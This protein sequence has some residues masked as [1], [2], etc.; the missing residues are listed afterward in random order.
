MP[1]MKPPMPAAVF[2]SL[3][4]HTGAG[5]RVA[6]DFERT[7]GP[8]KRRGEAAGQH[9]QL[10]ARKAFPVWAKPEPYPQ[11]HRRPAGRSTAGRRLQRDFCVDELKK[12][13]AENLD[14]ARRRL[15]DI[16]CNYAGYRKVCAHPGV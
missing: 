6:G 5:Q 8:I 10:A 1:P 11:S 14:A 16:L 3:L 9:D 2:A 7:Y 13:A 15:M 12:I 4:R